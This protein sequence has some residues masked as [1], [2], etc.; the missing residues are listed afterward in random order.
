MA[1][2]LASTPNSGLTTQVCGD[3]HLIELRCLR[4][5][6]TAP[7]VRHQRLRRDAARPV[8]VGRQAP[9]GELRHR[10]ARQQLLDA[11]S[12]RRS[13]L[14]RW[15]AYRESMREFAAMSNLDVWYAQIDVDAGMGADDRPEASTPHAR[16]RAEANIA[17]ARTRD[18]GHALGKFT[19][20]R[21]RRAADHQR[22][23]ARPTDRGTGR[24]EWSTTRS[25]RRC[26]SS[27]AATAA[28]CRATVATCSRTIE[29]VHAA[30]KVVGVGS[31]GTRAWIL[32]LMGRDDG[33]PLFLQAK[34]ANPS[35]LEE[36]VGQQ[37]GRLAR[38]AGRPRPAPDAGEQRHLPRLGAASRASTVSSATS[39]SASCA[40]G[41]D[42]RSSRP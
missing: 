36:F 27:S 33:D 32:L 21:R 28:R 2:D 41:R 19:T 7:R 5:P 9:R 42:R 34:E 13:L 23:A 37:P 22:S 15:R 16:K 25:W 38:R 14:G 20:H 8:G 39:T 11:R 6:G 1:A 17:K 29:L 35:V 31:V 10:R 3:A 26:A 40:T 18:S 4:L 30:R 24:R 12:V